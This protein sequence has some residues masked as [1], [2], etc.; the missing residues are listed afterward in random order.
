MLTFY[1]FCH[2]RERDKVILKLINAHVAIAIYTL[3]FGVIYSL[4]CLSVNGSLQK[5]SELYNK[6]YH[7][8]NPY[9]MI[10]QSV[11]LQFLGISGN[12]SGVIFD[13]YVH[14]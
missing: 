9:G 10:W 1:R 6:S 8:I 14:S 2:F 11:L 3:S 4:C 5:V 7:Q 12:L 13:N